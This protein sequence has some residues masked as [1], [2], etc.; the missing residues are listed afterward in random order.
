MFG[1]NG[2]LRGITTGKCFVE[3]ST[4]DEE[5]VQDVAEVSYRL[6]LLIPFPLIDTA[7]VV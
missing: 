1:S 6:S 2:V 3:M 7:S 5:T 4:I